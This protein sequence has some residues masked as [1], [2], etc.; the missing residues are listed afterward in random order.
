MI[1]FS[2]Q[3]QTSC[4]RRYL[5]IKALNILLLALHT[6]SLST[7]SCLHCG[8]SSSSTNAVVITQWFAYDGTIQTPIRSLL[9][10]LID[11]T[12]MGLSFDFVQIST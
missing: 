5:A 12:E 6:N 7:L 10:H 1:A 9:T 4:D 8:Y 3:R 11:F 2:L